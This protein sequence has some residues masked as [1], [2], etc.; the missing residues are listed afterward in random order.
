MNELDKIDDV[1]FSEFNEEGF[2][3]YLKDKGY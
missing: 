2:Q 1:K 3:E